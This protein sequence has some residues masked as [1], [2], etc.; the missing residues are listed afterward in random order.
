MGNFRVAIIGAG[1]I[2]EKMAFTL[3][4]M[5][6][7]ESYAVAS[8]SMEKAVSF[9]DKYNVTK[10]YGSYGDI[11]NDDN[12]DLVYVATPH[13]LHYE[14][15]ELILNHNKPVLCEKSFT[16]NSVQAEK[17]MEISER[18]N[19]F[20]SEAIWTRYMPLSL[21]IKDLL[22][23][24]VIGT[25]H[26][27]TANLCYPIIDKERI[28]NLSL[29]G[30]ALLDIGVYLLNFAAMYFGSDIDRIESSC[31]KSIS[32]VDVQDSI[33]VYFSGQRM[34]VMNCSVLALSDRSGVISGDKGFMV[35]DN[36]NNPQSVKIYNKE[37]KL[38]ECIN[39][40]AQITGLEY[41]VRAAID[42]IKLG[43][44]ETEYMPHCETVRIMRQ[45][46]DLR[47]SWGIKFPFE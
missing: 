42:S 27:I 11:L 18:K 20:I 12:I 33:T 46:D 43:K 7:V 21:K 19:V 4:H 47:N 44:I 13:S 17:L 22:D 10:A 9:A 40:P 29:A 8:R 2:A 34:A 30:G 36:I 14:H 24:D 3:S 41:E 25:P 23:N 45:M 26:T 5:D 31:T 38:V 28:S 6:G 16:A 39:A 37:Y 32:G 35:V 15:A 1:H